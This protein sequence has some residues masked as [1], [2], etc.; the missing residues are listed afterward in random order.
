MVWL[1]VI[2]SFQ[3][4]QESTFMQLTDKQ[5]SI[6]EIF[7]YLFVYHIFNTGRKG[8]LYLKVEGIC[9]LFWYFQ[10]LMGPCSLPNSN[11]TSDWIHF[12]SC[13]G[14][15]PPL[16]RYWKF[17]FA[18]PPPPPHSPEACPL[19]G[20]SLWNMKICHSESSILLPKYSC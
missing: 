16:P 12:S 10:I 20:N 2:H 4:F 15:P 1:G 6:W 11:L 13:A 18:P 5:T 8:L 9:P 19:F 7:Q 14:P 17:G 3:H